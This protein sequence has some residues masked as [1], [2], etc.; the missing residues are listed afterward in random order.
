MWNPPTSR[1]VKAFEPQLNAYSSK[2]LTK[3]RS[4][5]ED[6]QL[7][8][9]SEEEE[10]MLPEIVPISSL[11][12]SFSDD[13]SILSS[14]PGLASPLSTSPNS[15]RSIFKN[16]WSSPSSGGCGGGLSGEGG[17]EGSGGTTEEEELLYKLSSLTMP[18][19]DEDDYSS[20]S[21]TTTTASSTLK[22]SSSAQAAPS[23]KMAVPR[24]SSL[25][26]STI[27]YG[28]NKRPSSHCTP[29]RQILPTVAPPPPT[30]SSNVSQI[31]RV[32]PLL[33]EHSQRKWSS[34]TALIKRPTHS[35]LRPSRY[36]CS[37]IDERRLSQQQDEKKKKNAHEDATIAARS[38]SKSVSF[39]SQVSVFEFVN[40][41]GSDEVR[42]KDWFKFFA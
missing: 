33:G 42:S 26:D 19:V 6:T 10:D 30:P 2:K 28:K 29:R 25:D 38:R 12:S 41:K 16:Y 5:S 21:S 7:S 13:S 3:A 39:Y 4:C 35:C 1:Y 18:F 14:S 34:T 27:E 17:K 20:P 23:P 31:Q 11:G 37:M 9:S 15:P 8:S 24:R 40:S 32:A 22:R 36:S